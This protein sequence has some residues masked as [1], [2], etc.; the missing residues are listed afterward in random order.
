MPRQQQQE[1][2]A[3]LLDLGHRLTQERQQGCRWWKQ[4]RRLGQ[5]TQMQVRR[6]VRRGQGS[7]RR[8]QTTMMLSQVFQPEACTQVCEE[9]MLHVNW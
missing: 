2:R 8:S 7:L 6:V 5:Q 4:R 9:Q 1:L 3:L